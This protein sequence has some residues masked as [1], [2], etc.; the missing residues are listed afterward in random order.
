MTANF[1]RGE[2]EIRSYRR[3]S[4]RNLSDLLFSALKEIL[5]QF[6]MHPLAKQGMNDISV[7]LS[8]RVQNN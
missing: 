5:R 1:Q 4:Q 7:S 8:L 2:N 6:E 3:G